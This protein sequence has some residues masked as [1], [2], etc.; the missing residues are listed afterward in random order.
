M[1]TANIDIF[2][3]VKLYQ[4]DVLP[5]VVLDKIKTFTNLKSFGSLK[6]IPELK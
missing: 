6:P 2:Q 1:S 5:V 4:S 3:G